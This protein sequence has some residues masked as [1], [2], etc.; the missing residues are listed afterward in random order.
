[1]KIQFTILSFIAFIG[2][3]FCQNGISM[4]QSDSL[5][6]N[7]CG[8]IVFILAEAYSS[9]SENEITLS[10]V[11]ETLYTAVINPAYF[12]SS[13]DVDGDSQLRI[14]QLS[15]A[16]E[17]IGTY[18]SESHPDGFVLQ[19]DASSFRIEFQTGAGSGASFEMAIY[20]DST[21]N[22]LAETKFKLPVTSDW[23]MSEELGLPV[24]KVCPIDSFAIALE[25]ISLDP[26][27]QNPIADSILVKWAM[28]DRT[29]RRG[30]GL[31]SI[32][33]AYNEGKAY[34]ASVHRVRYLPC[35]CSKNSR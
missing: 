19:I 25:P 15:P 12:G 29:F 17:L 26:A 7:A 1:M 27:V 33:H 34:L 11:D 5:T 18:N 13:W 2:Q 16:E 30:L 9:E 20:C 31:T 28:G 3:V 21:F 22:T 14:F 35:T 8:D 24:L 32:D 23:S 10:G 4:E 6:L